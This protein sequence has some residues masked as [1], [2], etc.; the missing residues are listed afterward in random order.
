MGFAR[1][2]TVV[3]LAGLAAVETACF[4]PAVAATARGY[5]WSLLV[6]AVPVA[7]AVAGFRFV[8]PATWPDRRRRMLRS[9]AILVP[10]VSA[11]DFMFAGRFFR[12]PEAR[13]TLGWT[14]PDVAGH[15]VPVEEYAFY[16]L[17][18]A[19]M[20][21][22]YE[23]FA[24]VAVEDA[25]PAPVPVAVAGVPFVAGVAAFVSGRAPYL[26]YLLAAPATAAMS[27]WAR[28]GIR[29]QA[30]GW[31]IA[32]MLALSYTWEAALAL[33]RGWWGYQEGALAGPWILGVPAEAVLVWVLAPITTA[34][35]VE[36]FG[37]TRR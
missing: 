17:G 26:G 14:L 28:G 10:M 16:V 8:D 19:F 25:S 34:A 6:F 1:P 2:R 27:G 33:P 12:F 21:L 20:L 3:G 22:V 36:G 9:L 29:A 32:V 35:V 37:R 30:L 11:L 5:T 31:T 7:I 13:A 4:A 15:P 23:G 24:A 18:F